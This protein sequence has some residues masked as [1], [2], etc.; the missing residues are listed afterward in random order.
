MYDKYNRHVLDLLTFMGSVGG[1]FQ[2]LKY[3][4][5]IMF[6]TFAQWLLMSKIIKQVY[7]VRNYENL[8]NGISRKVRGQKMALK[9][10]E[11][12]SCI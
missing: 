9:E 11:H 1:L 8:D 4:G 12:Q 2:T 3:L 6:G 10:S 7:Q 5:I